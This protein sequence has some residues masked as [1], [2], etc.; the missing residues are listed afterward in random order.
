LRRAP[1]LDESRR[2]WVGDVED[3]RAHAARAEVADVERVALSQDLHA[4]AEAAEIVVGEEAHRHTVT[5]RRWL[6]CVLIAAPIPT[7]I[8]FGPKYQL[9]PGP[10][11]HTRLACSNTPEREL[12]HVELFANKLVL[13]VPKGIGVGRN[14]S[15]GVRTTQPTGVVEFVPAAKPTLGDLFDVW[16]QPLS[17]RGFAGFRGAVSAWVG[18]R[19]WRGDVRAIPLRRHAEVVVEVGGYIPPHRFFLFPPER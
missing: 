9:D 12:A 15:Y 10:P 11:A 7:P 19:R 18:G 5:V 16:G 3:R 17:A 4:V 14:C 2:R 13:L 8:G 6:A 1:L